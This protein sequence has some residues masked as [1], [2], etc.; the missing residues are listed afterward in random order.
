M[1]IKKE[2][3]HTKGRSHKPSRY[4][5]PEGVEVEF[6]PGSRGQVLGGDERHIWR[7]SEKAM[8]KIMSL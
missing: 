6:E 4:V 3:K 5:T 1:A 7:P 8:S 2:A